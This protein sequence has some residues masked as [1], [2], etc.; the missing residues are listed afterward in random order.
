[1]GS[2]LSDSRAPSVDHPPSGQI[3]TKLNGQSPTAAVGS[4]HKKV[5][6]QRSRS[7][8]TAAI[9]TSNVFHGV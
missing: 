8:A 1:M 3:A 7:D 5:S 2:I 9:V 6:H 4:P